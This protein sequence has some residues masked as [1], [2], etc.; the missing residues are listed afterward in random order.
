MESS[1]TQP[2]CQRP[3]G[4]RKRSDGCRHPRRVRMQPVALPAGRDQARADC[5]CRLRR[6][7]P[8]PG[9]ARRPESWPIGPCCLSSSAECVRTL[10]FLLLPPTP[11]PV[12][13]W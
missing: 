8:P 3:G 2:P 7:L 12:R 10:R 13:R 1:V 11:A 4:A 6:A 9:D 5:G